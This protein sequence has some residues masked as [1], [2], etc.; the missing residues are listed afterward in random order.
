MFRLHQ[1]Q[2]VDF[3][4]VRAHARPGQKRAPKE[5]PRSRSVPACGLMDQVVDYFKPARRPEWISAAEYR[6]LP[7]SFVVRELRYRI[8][9]PGFRTR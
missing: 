6:Q 7:E 9:V 1:K 2:I 5:M 8:A 4:P 3:T